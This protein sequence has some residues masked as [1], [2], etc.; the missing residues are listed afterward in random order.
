MNLAEDLFFPL[1]I[2]DGSGFQQNKPQRC[3]IGIKNE[4]KISYFGDHNR[5]WTVI[6]KKKVFTLFS[7]QRAARGFNSFSKS[8]PSC[9]IIAYPCAKRTLSV[10]KVWGSITGPVKSTQCRQRLT[11]AAMFLRSCVAQPLSRGDGPRNSLHA[12]A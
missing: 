11:T 7:N 10:R 4:V 3:K 12:S 9:E 6:S 5:T 2:M 8:G 1:E